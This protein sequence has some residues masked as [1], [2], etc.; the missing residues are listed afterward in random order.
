MALWKL[1]YSFHFKTM[2][3]FFFCCIIS[4]LEYLS[5]NLY[6]LSLFHSCSFSFYQS[7]YPISLNFLP[8]PESQCLGFWASYPKIP[9]S[10]LLRPQ[11]AA[12]GFQLPVVMPWISMTNMFLQLPA[13]DMLQL[14]YSK[15][16]DLIESQ[17]TNQ[18][19][20]G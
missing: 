10:F 19:S 18:A 2:I 12:L 7:K 11:K 1:C 15:Y 8:E 6:F 9:L 13:D 16:F 20:K 4:A 17:N 14:Y 3:F 5:S